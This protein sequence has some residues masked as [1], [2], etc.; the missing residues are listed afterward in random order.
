VKPFE[1]A[2]D[3]DNPLGY[4]IVQR[5]TSF[6][7]VGIGGGISDTT[8]GHARGHVTI[9]SRGSGARKDRVGL[10]QGPARD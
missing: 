3:A 8:R 4:G 7:G 5:E 1:R 10:P 9:T 2:I 6:E